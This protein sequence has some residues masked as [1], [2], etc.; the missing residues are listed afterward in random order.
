[1]LFLGF[2]FENG[3]N[4]ADGKKEKFHRI[5]YLSKRGKREFEIPEF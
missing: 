3:V 1:M 2:C 5:R 4:T